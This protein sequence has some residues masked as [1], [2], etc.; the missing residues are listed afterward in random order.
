MFD[1]IL[2]QWSWD[3]NLRLSGTIVQDSK[4]RF[5]DGERV[6]TSRLE[7]IERK[8]GLCIAHTRSGTRYLLV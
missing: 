6:I 7:R 8:H 3:D 1:A 2:S 4:G 5:D